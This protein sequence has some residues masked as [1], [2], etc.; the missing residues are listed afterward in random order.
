MCKAAPCPATFE[1]SYCSFWIGRYG[2]ELLISL[3][4]L[5]PISL[6]YIMFRSDLDWV[7]T[8]KFK[9]NIDVSPKL[10]IAT[11]YDLKDTR[12]DKLTDPS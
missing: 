6:S 11:S 7:F 2:P 8:T 12:V 5:V 10:I 9:Y 3:Q 4:V 1:D